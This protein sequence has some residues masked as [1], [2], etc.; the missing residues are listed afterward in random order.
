MGLFRVRILGKSRLEVF[1]VLPALKG[2][3][4]LRGLK[5]YVT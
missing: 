2:F 1:V 4:D 5:D 3:L